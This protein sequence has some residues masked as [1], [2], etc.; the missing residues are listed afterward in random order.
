MKTHPIYF[1]WEMLLQICARV[2]SSYCEPKEWLEGG[3]P[4]PSLCFYLWIDRFIILVSELTWTY[5]FFPALLAPSS[6]RW[7]MVSLHINGENEKSTQRDRKSLPLHYSQDFAL[8]SKNLI[9]R[10]QKPFDASNLF[11]SSLESA[12]FGPCVKTPFPGPWIR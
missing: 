9:G 10:S 1:Q 5:Y 3:T 11:L 7:E 4:K 2:T 8:L 12:G 6:V